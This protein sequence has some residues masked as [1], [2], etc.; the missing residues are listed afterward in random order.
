MANQKNDNVRYETLFRQQAGELC[1]L[2]QKNQQLRRENTELRQRLRELEASVRKLTDTKTRFRF[3][4]FGESSKHNSPNSKKRQ[5]K[6]RAKASYQRPRPK[7][8]DI[9]SRQELVLETCPRCEQEVSVSQKSYHTWVEDIVFAPKMV[10][11]YTVHR[12]WC[13]NC[14]KL[15][16]A[17]LPNALPG[18]HLGLNTM[19]FVL[20][21]HYCAKKTG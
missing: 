19:I 7:D 12:H 20:L 15:V 11:E 4:L 1:R 6:K 8:D 2:R 21:E 16:R 13:N 18:M 14:Q 9:T 10:T 5:P 3:F 17:P